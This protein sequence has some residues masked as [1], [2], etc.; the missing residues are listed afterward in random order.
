MED[1]HYNS[2][3][4]TWDDLRNTK[5]SGG[6]NHAFCNG[7]VGALIARA[8]V[9]SSRNFINKNYNL[10]PVL[11]SLINEEN[12]GWC[13]GI[14]SFYELGLCLRDIGLSCHIDFVNEV[15]N[16]KFQQRPILEDLT[17]FTGWGGFYYIQEAI[18]TN[19]TL[20]SPLTFKEYMI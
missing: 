9:L 8:E 10:A 13:H 14:S 12:L 20:I 11:K 3:K 16:N 18:K 4:G 7:S 2:S 15:H 5:H 19:K 17:L 6:D 1:N